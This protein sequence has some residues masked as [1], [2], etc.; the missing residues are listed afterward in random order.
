MWYGL[1]GKI[2]SRDTG[3]K[4]VSITHKSRGSGEELLKAELPKAMNFLSASGK[5]GLP[6][7]KVEHS[8]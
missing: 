5:A 6:V 8:I 7:K 4:A 2:N 1:K 3:E